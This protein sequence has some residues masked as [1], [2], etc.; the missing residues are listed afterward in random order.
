MLPERDFPDTKF[1]GSIFP[2]LS[3]R[4]RGAREYMDSPHCNRQMLE[5]TYAQFWLINAVVSGWRQIYRDRIRPAL[6][7]S[8]PTTLLDIGAG[9]GDVARALLR[10]AVRDGLRLEI[11]ATDPDERAHAYAAALA[12]VRGLQLRR[13]YS[14]ELVAEG[15]VY[16]VVISN[17]MLHHLEEAELISLLA[18]SEQ[19]TGRQV[20]H[21]DIE[22]SRAGFAGFAIATWPFFGNSFIRPDGLTSIRRSY[23]RTELAAAVPEGWRVQVQFPYQMLLTYEAAGS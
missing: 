5:R 12:P 21:A 14:T 1:P 22:R 10:W 6:S 11:T 20:I 16:D 2:D 8:S 7:T 9:G 13:A 19:L 4:A 17:H 18:D 23:T 15:A 3:R